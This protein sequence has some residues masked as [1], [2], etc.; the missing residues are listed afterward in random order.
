MLGQQ[1]A[2]PRTQQ[3]DVGVFSEDVLP[4]EVG[5]PIDKNLLFRP[6]IDQVAS[7]GQVTEETPLEIRGSSLRYRNDRKYGGVEALTDDLSRSDAAV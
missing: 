1:L 4:E 5:P 3:F 7:P 2:P 6:G